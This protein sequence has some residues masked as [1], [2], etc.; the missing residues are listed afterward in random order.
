MRIYIAGKVTGDK[1][2]LEK[3]EKAE[4]ALT[5][6]GHEPINPTCLRLPKSCSWKD[7]MALTLSM[8]DLAETVC[9]LPDWMESPGA[10]IEIGYAAAKGIDIITAD[11]IL[12]HPQESISKPVAS[13]YPP[14]AET[15]GQRKQD[16]R[17]EEDQ[18]MPGVREIL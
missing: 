4:A 11:Q 2:Y 5:T 13:E 6:I 18:D 9:L 1:H 17:T 16:E 14:E 15:G 12:P 8:L 3:F 10:C 7:Y